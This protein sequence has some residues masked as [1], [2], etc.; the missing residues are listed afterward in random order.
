VKGAIKVVT[1][2]STAAKQVMNDNQ[3]TVILCVLL[4]LFFYFAV[5]KPEVFVHSFD[6]SEITYLSVCIRSAGRGSQKLVLESSRGELFLYNNP[7]GFFPQNMTLK[8][9]QVLLCQSNSAT[10]WLE[11]DTNFIKGIRTPAFSIQPE[12]GVY[13]MNEDRKLVIVVILLCFMGAIG[14]YLYCIKVKGFTRWLAPRLKVTNK[15]R[16]R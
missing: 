10:V 14:H 4:G 3:L 5:Y 13:Y 2:A 7:A 16:L 9:A 15:A 6:K 8:E 12:Q 11:H 1:I